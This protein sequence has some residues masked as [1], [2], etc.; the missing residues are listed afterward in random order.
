MDLPKIGKLAPIFKGQAIINNKVC[1]ISSSDFND[2][3]LVL[4]FFP[5]DL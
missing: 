3:Y 4:L 1:D 5:M 2:K